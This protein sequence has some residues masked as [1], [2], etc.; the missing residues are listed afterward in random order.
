[1]ARR[2]A[3][4]IGNSEYADKTL[5]QLVTPGEDAN[6]LAET[7]RNPEIGG[8]DDVAS[9]INKEG[10]VVRREIARFFVRKKRDD[11]LLLHFSGHG[12]RDERGVLY[13]A[14]KDTDHDLL[15]RVM[16]CHTTEAMDLTNLASIRMAKA[17]K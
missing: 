6:D 2:Y 4:I 10:S 8:F 7:L 17:T 15:E 16:N 14:V 9:L 3:L 1:M 13:L 12:V 11:L 5:T